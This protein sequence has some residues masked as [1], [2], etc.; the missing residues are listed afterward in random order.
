MTSFTSSSNFDHYVRLRYQL[1]NSL[2]LTLPFDLI[3]QTGTLLPLLSSLC[4]RRYQEG[5]SPQMIIKEF[6]DEYIP[7]A[8]DRKQTDVLFHFVKYIERQVVLFDAIEEAAFDKIHDLKGPGTIQDT[9]D[10]VKDEQT[11]ERLLSKLQ[12]FR[13][14][15]IL[16]AH[17]T[18]FYPGPVLGIITDLAGAIRNNDLAAVNEYLLQL[19]K[20]PFIN[21]QKPTP[22]DEARSLVWYLE[23]VFYKAITHVVEKIALGLT[24]HGVVLMRKDLICMGFWPGGDRDGNPFVTADITRQTA[25]RLRRAIVSCYHRDVRELRRRLTFQDVYDRIVDIEY[26]L[27]D[28]IYNGPRSYPNASVLLGDLHQILHVIL[29]EH[30]ELFADYVSAFIK[31]VEIFGFFFATLDIRQDSRKHEFLLEVLLRLKAGDAYWHEF[32]NLSEQDKIEFLTNTSWRIHPEDVSD[33]ISKDIIESIVAMHDIQQENG[34]QACHRYVISNTRNALDVIT[35]LSLVRWTI[36]NTKHIDIVPLFETIDDLKN[37]GDVMGV[38]YMNAYYHEHLAQRDN[39]QTIMLGFS[40]GTKDGG[41]LRANWSIFQAKESLTQISRQCNVHVLFFDGRGG[42]PSRGGGNTHKFYSSL[43][44]TIENKEVQLTIQG[45]T[46]SSNF[47]YHDTAVYN[48]EQLFSAGIENAVFPDKESTHPAGNALSEKVRVLLDEMAEVSYE[49]YSVLKQRKEFLHYL[50][51]VGTLDYYGGT[52]VG[53][54]PV[55]RG[56]KS[57]LTLDSLR[58]IPFTGSWSQMKQNVPGYFG[59]GTA[60]KEQQ[61]KTHLE[62]VAQLYRSSR[63]FQTL[64]GNSM[65]SLSK[66][67]FPLTAYLKEDPEFGAFWEILYDEYELTVN[68]LLKISGQNALMEDARDIRLSIQMREQIVLPLLTIQQAALQKIRSGL[69]TEELEAVY[70]KLVLRTMYGIINAGRNVA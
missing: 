55:K 46:V 7:G 65:Q 34:V 51:E 31:R 30:D 35:P 68:F 52:N 2:F 66:S 49:S 36:G 14:R 25:A 63:F 8:D 44:P 60:I 22:L 40:D 38:L 1:Y 33:E 69:L 43:G 6:F 16:T 70:R 61:N 57:A 20:T 53:S 64:V 26:R 39:Q 21:R 23:N 28:G 19:G 15:I 18:Q 29:T 11:L 54:R 27:F 10:R 56:Q 59:F 48:I 17:P 24:R 50:Q 67:F 12:N 3:H 47:G 5:A 45:Q 4:E 9:F 42:P 62:D 41:Y 13:L 32:Q 37:A 58:A